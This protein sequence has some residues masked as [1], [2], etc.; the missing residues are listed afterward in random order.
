MAD[1][2]HLIGG[3]S[4]AQAKDPLTLTQVTTP[5]YTAAAVADWLARCYHNP[6]VPLGSVELLISSSRQGA[7]GKPPIPPAEGATMAN[8]K[9]AFDRWVGRAGSNPGNIALFYFCGHGLSKVNQ[10]LLPSDFGNPA[11]LDAWENCIDFDGM[12]VG[13]RS[14]KAQTQLFFV[15]ACRE[16]PFGVLTKEPRGHRLIDSDI[17][18]NVECSAVYHA[19]TEG[20]QAFGPDDGV[21][22]FGQAVISCLDGVGAMRRGA[23]WFVDTYS[24]GNALGQVMAR[25]GR[26]H[27]LKLNCNPSPSGMADIHRT[28]TPRVYAVVGCTSETANRAAEIVLEKGATRVHSP[29]GS[30]KPIFEELEAGRWKIEVHFPNGGFSSPYLTEEDL[31]PPIFEGVAVP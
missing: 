11:V 24:L 9:A 20:K 6:D 8:V 17:T 25:L 18:D 13:M 1:Y 2:P 7:P 26:R 23:A 22:Y 10:F 27:K 21:S 19:A 16:I 3:D 30:P 31:M 4:A 5:Q 28:A 14:C 12:R 29:F 15:D